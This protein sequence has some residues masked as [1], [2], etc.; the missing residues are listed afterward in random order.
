MQLQYNFTLK[1][2][3]N[4]SKILFRLIFSGLSI[5]FLTKVFFRFKLKYVYIEFVEKNKLLFI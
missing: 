5:K 3:K 1:F 2:V 4:Q